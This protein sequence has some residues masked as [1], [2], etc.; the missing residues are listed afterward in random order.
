M[1]ARTLAKQLDLDRTMLWGDRLRVLLNSSHISY[2]EINQILREKGIFLDSSD[3]A[4]TVP[5]LSFC[6]LTPSEFSRL[7]NRSYKR[8]ST[9]K[10]KTDKYP[11]FSDDA[12]WCSV[13]ENNFDDITACLS[14]NNEIEF[15]QRPRFFINKSGD[16]EIVYIL[17]KEDLSKDWIEQELQFSGGLIISRRANELI[18]D[19]LKTHTAKETDRINEIILRGITRRWKEND[20]I[21]DDKPQSIR[22]DDFNNEERINFFLQLTGANSKVLSFKELIDMDI[23][24]DESAGSLPADPNISWMD[25]GV[26]RIRING[27][28]LDRFILLQNKTFHRYCFL[29]KMSSVYKFQSGGDSG[30]CTVIFWFG[31]RNLN[32]R[33]LA[34]TELNISIE[35]IS[36]KMSRESEKIIRRSILKSIWDLQESALTFIARQRQMTTVSAAAS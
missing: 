5:L 26:K 2:G 22:F 11:L 31:G 7:I 36:G 13:I 24:R 16:L 9:E 14:L 19:V 20:V 29:V 33:E 1:S 15:V 3:K 12:D 18:V 30:Q 8:E 17:K 32:D 23:V 25:G 6:L 21:K 27:E 10:Y 28:Q 34:N 4:V 35:K